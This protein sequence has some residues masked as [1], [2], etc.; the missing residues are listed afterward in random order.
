M[1]YSE[2]KSRLAQISHRNDLEPQ[3]ASF[4]DMAKERINRRFGLSLATLS[5]DADTN[6]VLSLWPILYL[7]ASLQALYEFLNNG[8]NATYYKDLWE[9]EAD[10]QNITGASTATDPLWGAQPPFIKPQT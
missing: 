10:R 9:Q 3:M 6:E 2:L 1:T 8:D 4:V 7:Y 5:G